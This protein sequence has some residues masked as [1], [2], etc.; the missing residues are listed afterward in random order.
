MLVGLVVVVLAAGAY[1]LPRLLRGPEREKP[2]AGVPVLGLGGGVGGSVADRLRRDLTLQ[3]IVQTKAMELVRQ[4]WKHPGSP[5]FPPLEQHVEEIGSSLYRATGL[6]T[7]EEESIERSL[8]YACEI[9]AANEK[10]PKVTFLR[11]G[12]ETVPVVAEKSGE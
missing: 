3:P 10:T 9:D 7:Y 5:T 1:E 4:H 8:T 11:I 2:A 6:V 12:E